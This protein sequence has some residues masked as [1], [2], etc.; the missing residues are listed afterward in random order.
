MSADGAQQELIAQAAAGDRA[1]LAQ[2]LLNA[3]EPLQR[4]LA[5]AIS[6][7]LQ[8]LVRQED[9][10][11]QVFVR[12]AQAIGRFQYHHPGSLLGWLT[13]IADNLIRDAERRRRRERRA[14]ETR[15]PGRGAASSSFGLLLD[16]LV[17]DSTTPGG[18]VQRWEH[19]RRLRGAIAS[20]PEEQREVIE[21]H[22]LRD[23]SYEQIGEAMGRSKD[24]VRG[25]SYRARQNLRDLM[26]R[27]SLYFSG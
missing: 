16:R 20:L 24:A 19:V 18:R 26:G 12:A 17:T 14:G 23:Q 13:T 11:Q 9:V 25:L 4:H 21:R 6:P 10:L 1:A 8:A 7:E 3:Y 5:S 2:L 22:Y 15:L 27:S